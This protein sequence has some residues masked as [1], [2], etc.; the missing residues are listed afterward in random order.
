MERT[1]LSRDE[2]N[3]LVN[4]Y[5][6]ADVG[7][8]DGNAVYDNRANIIIGDARG[9][10]VLENG[11]TWHW[12]CSPLIRGRDALELG[13]RAIKAAFTDQRVKSIRGSTPRDFRAARLM[14]R[15]L[16]ARPIGE[17]VDILGRRCVDY[18]LER[19]RCLLLLESP[20]PPLARPDR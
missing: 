16:G 9:V 8:L 7:R 10:V 12:I 17:S 14:N 1:G 15:A 11:C 19:D 5:P 4:G 2:F 3:A 13:R 20:E 6:G 18:L